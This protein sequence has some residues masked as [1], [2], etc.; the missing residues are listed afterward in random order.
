MTPKQVIEHD[1]RIG[2]KLF[3]VYHIPSDFQPDT[4]F[5]IPSRL[6]KPECIVEVQVVYIEKSFDPQTNFEYIQLTLDG[7]FNTPKDKVLIENTYLI[8]GIRTDKHYDEYYNEG[9]TRKFFTKEE[10]EAQLEKEVKRWHECME[11][12]KKGN[13]WF[14]PYLFPNKI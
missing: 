6:T 11:Q 5:D 8:A 1:W 2:E 3:V 10:A 14:S 4:I 12:W 7:D 9:C 13:M